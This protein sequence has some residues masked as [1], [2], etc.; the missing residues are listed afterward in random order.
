LGTAVHKSILKD[1]NDA[2]FISITTDSTMDASHKEIYTIIVRFVTNSNV[3]ERI[4]SAG[5]LSSKV[6]QDICEHIL[7]Q[8]KK[9]GIS[10]DKIIA[11][12]YD[13]APNM[14]GK[15]LGVQA[16]LSKYLNRKIMFIPC[17]AHSS[18]LII[19]HG[20]VVNI[21]YVNC[22]GILQELFNFFTDSIKRFSLLC[23]QLSKTSYCKRLSIIEVF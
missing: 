11:Q 13:N 5:E 4:I 21:E 15:N 19:K 6:G 9:C 20:S 3:Q 17:S 14:S 22:F 23:E 2:P 8:L 12:S 16:C 7:E 10:T 18:N 1:I